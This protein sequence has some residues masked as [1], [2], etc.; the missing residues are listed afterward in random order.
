MRRIDGYPLWIGTARDARDIRAVLDAEIE[1]VVDLAVEEPPVSPTRELVY[2]RFPLI[3]GE[4]NP[5][6]RLMAA[7]LAVEGLIRLRVPTLVACG[8]G[9]S[10]SLA[11]TAAGRCLA[12]DQRA[13]DKVLRSI[14][15]GAGPSDVHPALWNDIMRCFLTDDESLHGRNRAPD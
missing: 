13:P 15:G 12:T 14:T 4:G 5:Y 8:A 6:W 9:M 7:L 2:L 1:A 3:D 10:R 11:I